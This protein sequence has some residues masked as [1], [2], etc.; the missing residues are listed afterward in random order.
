MNIKQE[1]QQ[2]NNKLDKSSSKLVAAKKRG[3]QVIVLQF[4]SEI[5]SIKKQIAGRRAG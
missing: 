5:E 3:D 2:L 1:L 4:K